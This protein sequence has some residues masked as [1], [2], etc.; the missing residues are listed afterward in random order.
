MAGG[1]DLGGNTITAARR[2]SLA[3]KS[4]W[5]CRLLSASLCMFDN[6][7]CSRLVWSVIVESLQSQ[8]L[9]HLVDCKPVFTYSIEV[10]TPVPYRLYG[11][12]P[13]TARRRDYS[14]AA[15]LGY[16][17]VSHMSIIGHGFFIVVSRACFQG[18]SRMCSIVDATLRTKAN[19]T[20]VC[21]HSMCAWHRP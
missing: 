20:P 13:L 4:G 9:L 14:Y 11:V 18:F 2:K 5:V 21:T 3:G 10:L 16:N 6:W 1:A 19:V 8:F 12:F 15:V 17:Q 7:L